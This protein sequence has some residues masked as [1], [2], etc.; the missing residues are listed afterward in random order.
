MFIYLNLTI[1]KVSF[2]R[3]CERGFHQGFLERL[4]G[5]K[6]HLL[7]PIEWITCEKLKPF[8]AERVFHFCRVLTW[9]RPLD[10]TLGQYVASVHGSCD[11]VPGLETRACCTSCMIGKSIASDPRL[12]PTRRVCVSPRYDLRLPVTQQCCL[13]Q[14]Q[15][16]QWLCTKGLVLCSPSLSLPRS[17]S[18]QSPPIS[19]FPSMNRLN[20]VRLPLQPKLNLL[21]FTSFKPVDH[22]PNISLPFKNEISKLHITTNTSFTASSNLILHFP[23]TPSK[24]QTFSFPIG[25]V[26]PRLNVSRSFH[27]HQ[28]FVDYN[29]FVSARFKTA[30]TTKPNYRMIHGLSDPVDRSFL[31]NRKLN[32]DLRKLHCA[33]D[34]NQSVQIDI[35]QTVPT[36]L[37]RTK[38]LDSWCFLDSFTLHAKCEPPI[39][40]TPGQVP[41]QFNRR[42]VQ[43]DECKY[44]LHNCHPRVEFCLDTFD[45]F[46][47][48]CQRGFRRSLQNPT[49]CVNVD[50]CREMEKPC[51]L[52]SQCFDH[53]GRHECHCLSGFEMKNFE[54]VSTR[55]SRPESASRNRIKNGWIRDV[56]ALVT[57]TAVAIENV[58]LSS[59]P[60]NKSEE[61]LKADVEIGAKTNQTLIE[62][63]VDGTK[64]NAFI[65]SFFKEEKVPALSNLTQHA[66]VTSNDQWSRLR[67]KNVS[68]EN[69]SMNKNSFANESQPMS[70][71]N[72]MTTEVSSLPMA[73]RLDFIIN[74]T[75]VPIPSVQ[76]LSEKLDLPICSP[77]QRIQDE[78]CQHEDECKRHPSPCSVDFVCVSLNG[79]H[80][81]RIGA[82]STADLFTSGNSQNPSTNK[83]KSNH[84]KI[85]FWVLFFKLSFLLIAINLTLYVYRR[86]NSHV[87][88][89]LEPKQRLNS[90]EQ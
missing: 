16:N 89:D 63:I 8:E 43:L 73:T 44:I 9:R 41:N 60:V 54:C 37:N 10:C 70:N 46:I 72:S 27:D 75:R 23:P 18:F 7:R 26:R 21:N 29:A 88:F 69:P 80:E 31:P 42:C 79:S 39:S 36:H 24:N 62:T 12:D 34:C 28:A 47:C 35:Y 83:Q 33:L 25:E 76:N 38:T 20:S 2:E 5:P 32:V 58:T 81:C 90:Y 68:N 85:I 53:F 49:M 4:F 61:T 74:V 19:P 86:M 64:K 84:S 82:S 65:D 59:L 14:P 48:E 30:G 52:N 11:H 57:V 3:C 50:E 22:E 77:G 45:G 13:M 1:D 56:D 51:P 67:L 40:C 87:S 78:R 71:A 55:Q 17:T 6:A 15:A 66:N